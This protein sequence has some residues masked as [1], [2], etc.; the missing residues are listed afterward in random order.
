MRLRHDF[1]ALSRAF[2][3]LARGL[4]G[5]IELVV[6]KTAER[7]EE[8][9]RERAPRKTG[10]MAES[11]GSTVLGRAAIVG[12]R[13]SYARFLEF[14]TR[15][16]E[17]RPRRARALR[18]SIGGRMIFAR[19]VLHPGI[20]PRRFVQAAAEELQEELGSIFEEVMEHAIG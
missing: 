1:G 17:I 4:G 20:R 15:P 12:L 16:H 2:R 8:L 18:F 11:V 7:A 5:A 13:A 14:G 3:H 6:K 19:R 9:L 10:R